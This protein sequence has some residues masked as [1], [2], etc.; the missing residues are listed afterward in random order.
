MQTIEKDKELL[1]IQQETETVVE[2]AE[3]FML[4]SDGQLETA[5][6]VISW[7]AGKKKLIEDKRKF[8]VQPLND[9]VSKINEMFKGYLRPLDEA[10]AI[11]DEKILSYRSE[12]EE[13][14]IEM[15]KQVEKE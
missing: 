9:Q 10:R 4:D 13:K 3:K 1:G 5:A 2:R 12:L 8:F 15:E 11:M 14:R 6:K 7:I